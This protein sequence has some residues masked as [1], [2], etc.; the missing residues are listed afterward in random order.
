MGANTPYTESEADPE[1]RS[2]TRRGRAFSGEVRSTRLITLLMI[3]LLFGV[4]AGFL[5][6]MHLAGDPMGGL[7]PSLFTLIAV[8]SLGASVHAFVGLF[9]PRVR[10]VLFPAKPRLGDTVEVQWEI[11]LGEHPQ[12][13]QLWSPSMRPVNL[14][15]REHKTRPV[16][17]LH[18]SGKIFTGLVLGDRNWPHLGDPRGLKARRRR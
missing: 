18:S 2:E 13:G 9:A 15:A 5:W 3:A 1:A 16:K 6:K 4:V 17:N 8:L 7:F 14:A 11:D 12:P 10:V